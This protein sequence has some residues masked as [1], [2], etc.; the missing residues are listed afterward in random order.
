MIAPR[1]A[2]IGA[3]I[4]GG[5]HL[6]V[7][8]QLE[9]Q[10]RVHLAAFAARTQATVDSQTERF[11][12]KGFT[13]WGRMLETETLDAVTVATPDH[14]HY[15]MA[16]RAIE[17]GKHVLIEKPMVLDVAEA[18]SIVAAAKTS[19]VLVAVDYH[20]RF[21]PT[22]LAVKEL[23]ESP[24]AGQVQYGYMHL[25]ERIGF[26]T[27]EIR[28]WAER[29]NPSWIV[30]IH[31]YDVLR[32]L[33]GQEVRSVSATAVRRKLPSLGVDVADSTQVHLQFTGGAQIAVQ[34]SWILPDEFEAAVDQSLR[35]ITDN[36]II[37][38]DLQY[39]GLRATISGTPAQTPNPLF[40]RRKTRHDGSAELAGY[41]PDSIAEFVQN[42]ASVLSGVSLEDL[43][44]PSAEDGLAGVQTACAVDE[45][46][47]SGLTVHIRQ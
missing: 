12:V 31:C 30:G 4:Y 3:G 27:R 9:R 16:M 13:D 17:A 26:V 20:K 37:E 41:A 33:T 19:G 22:L 15:E 40:L 46:I 24:E 42:V 2:V 14:L 39:R 5:L 29:T 45:S 28:S 44:Y 11:R 10:E 47:R 38:A 43:D 21:D 6:E 25:E 34:N 23:L 18:E 36:G 7:L 32:W 1:I 8:K 35:L